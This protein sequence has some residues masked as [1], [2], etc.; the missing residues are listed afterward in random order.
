MPVVIRSQEAVRLLCQQI[1]AIWT[2]DKSQKSDVYFL[3]PNTDGSKLFEE[4]RIDPKVET[5]LLYDDV[6]LWNVSRELASKSQAHTL[7]KTKLYKSMTIRNVNTVRKLDSLMQST[8]TPPSQK[9]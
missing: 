3:L 7:I 9:S 2:N 1:P 5:V 4:L 6:L 8:S